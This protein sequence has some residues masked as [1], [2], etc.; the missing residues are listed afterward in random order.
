MAPR[1]KK[2]RTI[3]CVPS[4][5]GYNVSGNQNANGSVVMLYEE[6]EAIRLADYVHLNH[7]EASKY[8]NISRPTFAR[9]YELARQKIAL[10]FT[11]GL[12][13]RFTEGCSYFRNSKFNTDNSTLIKKSNIMERLIAIPTEN[14][15]L[16]THFGHAKE[17]S[18]VTVVDN[19]ISGIKSITP[20]EHA[21]G[22]IPKWVAE[23]GAS[24]V[25]VGGM[26]QQAIS[27]FQQNGVDVITGAAEK[28]VEEIIAAYLD[29]EKI[30][31]GNRCDH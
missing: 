28:S 18:F 11:E 19:K 22:V 10:A 2:C 27:L 21:P 13:F 31:A 25:V 6:L 14:G 5:S 24:L 30:D 9:I 20:P 1:R 3:G 23:Q 16:T 26:G 8:M 17:F 15:V 29:G 4:F 12:N 7:E